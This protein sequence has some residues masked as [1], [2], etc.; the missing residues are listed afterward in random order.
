M[1]VIYNGIN[2]NK[3]DGEVDPGAVKHTYGVGA[4]DPMF[5]FV[6]TMSLHRLT[7]YVFRPSLFFRQCFRSMQ[8]AANAMRLVLV[9]GWGQGL[10]ARVYGVPV[11]LKFPGGQAISAVVLIR[12]LPLHLLQQLLRQ[13]ETTNT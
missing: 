5:L 4:L 10:S 11:Y 9:A 8:N 12:L 13:E 6:G 2:C 7:A 1:T 3:F